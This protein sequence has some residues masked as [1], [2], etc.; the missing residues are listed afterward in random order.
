MGVVMCLFDFSIS[1]DTLFSLLAPSAL[2]FWEAVPRERETNFRTI[3][4]I[5]LEPPNPD[6]RLDSIA[7]R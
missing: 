6:Q 5:E 7:L 1:S 4:I 3:N 2:T